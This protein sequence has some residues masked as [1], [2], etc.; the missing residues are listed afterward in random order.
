M[1]SGTPSVSRAVLEPLLYP[2]LYFY[3]PP[4]LG[5][6][7]DFCGGSSLGSLLLGAVPGLTFPLLAGLAMAVR[8]GP[9]DSPAWVMTIVFLAIGVVGAGGGIIVSRTCRWLASRWRRLG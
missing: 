7:N 2:I 3:I 1:R 4:V 6:Y 8:T 5:A 9:A